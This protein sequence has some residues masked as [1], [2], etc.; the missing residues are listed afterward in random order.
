MRIH[1]IGANLPHVRLCSIVLMLIST[2]CAGPMGTIRGETPLAPPVTSFDGSYR[3][4]IRFIGAF[5]A[6]Q[7]ADWCNTPGQ[8][9]ITVTDGHFTYAVPHPDIPGNATPVYPA[10][11]AADG[12]FSGQII[13]G[14]IYGRVQGSRVEGKID[15]SAC[16]YTFTGDRV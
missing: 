8:P 12:S 16:V 14:M 6:A 4:T 10:T 5:G 13:A 9:I 2:G 1:P 15:G 3:N 7:T 11:M